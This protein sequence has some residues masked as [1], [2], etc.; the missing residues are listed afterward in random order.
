MDFDDLFTDEIPPDIAG[1]SILEKDSALALLLRLY[2]NN[3]QNQKHF[4]HL[5]RSLKKNVANTVLPDV[6]NW[7]N[8]T[9]VSLECECPTPDSYTKEEYV[10][11]DGNRCPKLPMPSM[12]VV[13]GDSRVPEIS[14]ASILA[15]V[16]RD[17]EMA[18]LDT[19]GTAWRSGKAKGATGRPVALL[20]QFLL[21]RAGFNGEE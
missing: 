11:I 6:M 19:V 12:A 7:S 15:K 21:N 13:K 14:A 9:K 20:A 17:A 16:T 1:D 10:L 2:A 3:T 18:A 5:R 8:G 4:A